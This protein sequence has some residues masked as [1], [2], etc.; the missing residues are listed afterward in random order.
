M[1]DRQSSELQCLKQARRS[2]RLIRQRLLNPTP[3][4]MDLCVPHFNV[5]ID[6]LT[7]LHVLLGAETSIIFGRKVL[8][9]EILDLRA[10]LAQVSALMNNAAAFY[11]GIA[12]LMG[13]GGEDTAGYTPAGVLAGPTPVTLQLEG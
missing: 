2:I 13:S 10:E 12:Q 3:K 6:C 5:A 11:A 9:A 8:R 1:M 7:Q 4:V